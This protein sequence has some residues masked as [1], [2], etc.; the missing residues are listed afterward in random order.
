M[1]D[2]P[3]YCPVCG[4]QLHRPAW[5]TDHSPSF[6]I[7]PCCG[8]QFGYDDF[9]LDPSDRENIRKSWRNKWI[10]GGMKFWSV[11]RRPANWDPLLQLRN[12]DLDVDDR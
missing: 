3:Y 6:E 9:A 1:T 10:E 4:F 2:G 11:R 8:L 7:C 5:I 12:A